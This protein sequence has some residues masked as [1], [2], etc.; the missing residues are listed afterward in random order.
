ME[1]KPITA[2]EISK[3]DFSTLT[4]DQI[5]DII[6]RISAVTDTDASWKLFDAIM[7]KYTMTNHKK[8]EKLNG[9][10]VNIKKIL[11]S[12]LLKEQFEIYKQNP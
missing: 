3:T 9:M 4:E 5:S 12:E 1:L 2:E 8:F 7:E 10:N 6:N 11:Y